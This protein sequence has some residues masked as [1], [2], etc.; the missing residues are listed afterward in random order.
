MPRAVTRGFNDPKLIERLTHLHALV[1]FVVAFDVDD[2][3]PLALDQEGEDTT[4]AGDI[5]QR[6]I[7]AEATQLNG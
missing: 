7:T 2:L 5:T 4:E 6:D 1:V 3:L